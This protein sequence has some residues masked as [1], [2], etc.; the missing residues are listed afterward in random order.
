MNILVTGKN[1]FIAKNVIHRLANKHNVMG[2]SHSDDDSLLES[3]CKNSDMIFHLAA[4]QRGVTEEE[5]FNGNVKYTKKLIYTL[6]RY[7]IKVPI[8]FTTSIRIDDNESVFSKTKLEAEKLVRLYGKENSV[9]AYVYKL[10][11]IFG[12]YGKENFNN[13]IATFC[14]NVVHHLPIVINN[15]AA[16]LRFTYIQDLVDEFEY[17][18]DTKPEISG[19]YLYPNIQYKKTLGEIVKIL[20]DIVNGTEQKN[21]FE[22][23]LS[24]TLDFYKSL[25]C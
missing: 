14:F 18:V 24:K 3:Y 11:N 2:V 21:E 10:N 25:C 12:E 4:V 1:G 8:L 15:P 23:K 6:D 22:K 5:F 9:K 17:I 16:S 13:V 7:N 20:G 19:R